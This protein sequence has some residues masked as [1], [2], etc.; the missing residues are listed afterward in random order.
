MWFAIWTRIQIRW[1]RLVSTSKIP[2]KNATFTLVVHRTI[3]LSFWIS[4]NILYM[5][6]TYHRWRVPILD[7]YYHENMFVW[8]E[9]LNFSPKSPHEIDELFTLLFRNQI[10]KLC[11]WSERRMIWGDFNGF[12]I[13]QY[14][15]SANINTVR[16]RWIIIFI[17]LFSFFILFGLLWFVAKELQIF[18]TKLFILHLRYSSRLASFA[19]CELFV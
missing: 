3:K 4:F 12:S 8:N 7:Y 10:H 13:W 5:Y 16:N 18:K 1:Y 6:A 14:E 17:F 2:R 15:R 9:W 11:K 19:M